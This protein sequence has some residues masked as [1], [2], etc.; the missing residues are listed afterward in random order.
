MLLA[1]FAQHPR[2]SVV[3]QVF[4]GDLAC[5]WEMIAFLISIH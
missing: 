4:V 3:H 5:F 2:H 1:K